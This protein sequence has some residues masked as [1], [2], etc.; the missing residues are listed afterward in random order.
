MMA[1]KCLQ[2]STCPALSTTS[3][4]HACRAWESFSWTE[5]IPT[6]WEGC[7]KTKRMWWWRE[8]LESYGSQ[9]SFPTWHSMI[10]WGSGKPAYTSA[11]WRV[12]PYS[13]SFKSKWMSAQK[14]TSHLTATLKG[15]VSAQWVCSRVRWAMARAL[16]P[17]LIVRSKPSLV[18]SLHLSR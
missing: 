3:Q 7:V 1:G 9:A 13:S 6:S 8:C 10:V 16:E 11:S 4:M 14:L 2:A 15:L 12:H 18:V 5:L 17:T